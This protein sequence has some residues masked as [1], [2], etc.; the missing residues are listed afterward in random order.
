MMF[1]TRAD[2]NDLI[3]LGS[4]KING[5]AEIDL[6]YPSSQLTFS[7]ATLKQEETAVGSLSKCNF[8]FDFFPNSTFNLDE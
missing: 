6:F 7:S 2:F 1:T 5:F 3:S 4:D 8:N